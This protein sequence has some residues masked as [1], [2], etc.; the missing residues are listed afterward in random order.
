MLFREVRA[1][2]VPVFANVRDRERHPADGD[3]SGDPFPRE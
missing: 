3:A 1:P 2:K